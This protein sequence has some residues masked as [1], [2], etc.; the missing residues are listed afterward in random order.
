LDYNIPSL[1][2]E[3]PKYFMGN[4]TVYDKNPLLTNTGPGD[5]NPQKAYKK[6]AYTLTGR[7]KE[8]TDLKFPGPGQYEGDG[9]RSIPGA[10]LGKNIRDTTVNDK[11]KGSSTGPGS[12]KVEKFA[13]ENQGPKF[14]FGS[15]PRDKGYIN[16]KG[17]SG[18]GPGNYDEK[19]VMGEGVPGYSITARRPDVRVKAGKGTPGPGRYDPMLG[20]VRRN[21]PKFGIG[22]QSKSKIANIY[23]QV[24][25]PNNYQPN[26][27]WTKK[28]AAS[29]GMGTNKR[30]GLS[31]ILD[32]PGPGQYEARLNTRSGPTL[33]SKPRVHVKDSPGPGTY[34]PDPRQAK[35]KA[36]QF[37]MG[38]EKKKT[39]AGRPHNKYPGPGTYYGQKPKSGPSF[40]FGSGKRMHVN[41]N[42]S[43]GPGSYK[44]PTKIRNVEGYALDKNNFSYV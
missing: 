21:G 42:D 44:I 32:T 13:A 15:D 18:P 27:T 17:A 12:Y 11:T 38:S 16:K 23:G 9:K 20:Y 24:P 31:Q 4:R 7:S 36:P 22:K 39:I 10:G 33:G 41:C 8:P 35:R 37:S 43:P 19:K 34:S 30:P 28:N 6:L 14:G 1:I 3:G 40:G 2:D 29:W 26:Q 25:G 5:Y